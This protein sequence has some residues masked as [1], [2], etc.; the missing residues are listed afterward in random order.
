MQ[1]SKGVLCDIQRDW[2]NMKN[3]VKIEFLKR[4]VIGV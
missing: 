1:Q 4:E 3:F 2:I